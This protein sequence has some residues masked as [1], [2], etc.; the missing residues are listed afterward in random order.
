MRTWEKSY[1]AVLSALIL[2]GCSL[3]EPDKCKDDPK[4]TEPG[5]CGC[6]FPDRDKDGDTIPDCV[7]TLPDLKNDADQD[8]D[9]IPN[10]DDT[11]PYD[12]SNQCCPLDPVTHEST[13]VN[14]KEN[15]GFCGCDKAETDSD[16]DTLPDCVDIC[17]GDSNKALIEESGKL[18]AV[19]VIDGRIDTKTETANACGCGNDGSEADSD[20]DTVPDCLDVCPDDPHK[21]VE[22][23]I[24]VCKCGE[25]VSLDSDGDTVP[26]CGDACKDNELI[27]TEEQRDAGACGCDKNCEPCPEGALFPVKGVCGCYIAPVTEGDE[28]N[29]GDADADGVADCVDI[30]PLNAKIT[31]SLAEIENLAEYYDSDDYKRILARCDIVDA[32][33]DGLMDDE[34]PCPTNPDKSATAETC[35][36]YNS[37][38][39]EFV[40]RYALDFATLREV[41]KK[42]TS[43]AQWTIK[44]DNTASKINLGHPYLDIGDVEGSKIQVAADGSC[45]IHFEPIS[46]KGAK[47][48]GNS[49][50]ITAV[51]N[52]KKCSLTN[53]IFDLVDASEITDLTL[54]YGVDGPGRG[55]LAND[56]IN[57]SRLENITV[58]DGSVKSGAEGKPVGGIVGS[59]TGRD[60]RPEDSDTS[61]GDIKNC[62]L[63]G[64]SVE[65]PKASATGGLIG[66]IVNAVIYLSD[67]PYHVTSVAGGDNVGGLIGEI[68]ST[69]L[70]HMSQVKPASDDKMIRNNVTRV[71]GNS[72]VAGFVGRYSCVTMSCAAMINNLV[73]HVTTVEATGN[74][75]GG[76]VGSI[77]GYSSAL[78]RI[79]NEVDSVSSTGKWSSEEDKRLGQYVGGVAG[80]YQGTASTVRNQ[81][82][83]VKGSQMVA[84]FAGG[85]HK[86][87]MEPELVNISSTVQSV[88]TVTSHVGGL[89]AELD[90]SAGSAKYLKMQDVAST[91]N[92]TCYEPSPWPNANWSCVMGGLFGRVIT[93]TDRQTMN[94]HN[95]ISNAAI[96][97][98]SKTGAKRREIKPM[99]APGFGTYYAPSDTYDNFKFYR[100]D[101]SGD[102]IAYN[103]ADGGP[104]HDKGL[105]FSSVDVDSLVNNLERGKA[106]KT[107]IKWK[108]ET[109]FK[110]SHNDVPSK[111]P[112]LKVIGLSE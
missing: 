3:D 60:K 84:G 111:L 112:T 45:S 79:S 26:D 101:S 21:K 5:I 91:A 1:I 29:T 92:V 30:C 55:L 39:H 50:E 107:S 44:F 66:D 106:D 67:T 36:V 20:N 75:V 81:V 80:Y 89:I 105:G 103:V 7:D 64:I 14:G 110:F 38:S 2:A 69:S 6:G 88:E 31:D 18:Y 42:D 24:A 57:N 13:G 78:K 76:V 82:S 71:S 16:G 47:V 85:Y 87:N 46:L 83:S 33:G 52:D 109:S 95:V 74:Y 61:Y 9:T 108:S 97:F 54:S 51:Y 53:P 22:S 86:N 90:L 49:H 99:I 48:V 94:F 17:S 37:S 63:D 34:D 10:I 96:Y 68:S 11:C 15:P 104:W 93:G 98:V 25:D 19:T 73:N 40:I 28:K 102:E 12:K 65:A 8:G 4:K 77:I 32:D 62:V 70:A 35:K 41:L 56:L 58:K 59:V 72:Y 43:N 100:H 27:Q 23:D